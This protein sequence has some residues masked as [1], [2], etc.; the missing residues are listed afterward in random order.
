MFNRRISFSEL[1][2][3]IKKIFEFAN[4][5]DDRTK[6]SISETLHYEIG[7]IV[8]AAVELIVALAESTNDERVKNHAYSFLK[9]QNIAGVYSDI[10]E[11]VYKA[12]DKYESENDCHNLSIYGISADTKDL[13][14]RFI[15]ENNLKFGDIEESTNY[16]KLNNIPMIK[17]GAE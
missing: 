13:L 5:T 4:N 1:V 8:N 9:K 14:C 15:I 2:A 12:L 17:D 6:L 16:D 11:K 7:E 10:S 3:E